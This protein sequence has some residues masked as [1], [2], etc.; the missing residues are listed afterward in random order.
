MPVTIWI[1][2]CSQDSLPHLISFHLNVQMADYEHHAI[3]SMFICRR[4]P[5]TIQSAMSICSKIEIGMRILKARSDFEVSWI[6]GL[7]LLIL[8]PLFLSH[9]E[10]GCPRIAPLVLFV[11]CACSCPSTRSVVE[12]F[13]RSCL[14]FMCQQLSSDISGTHSIR[15]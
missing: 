1:S 4:L 3:G 5:N 9:V 13:T 12:S 15:S 8:H 7:F 6:G 2:L 11:I 10:I 14:G